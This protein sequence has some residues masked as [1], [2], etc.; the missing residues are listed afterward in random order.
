MA[1]SDT[2]NTQ[3]RRRS[4]YRF[5]VLVAVA[6]VVLLI[7]GFSIPGVGWLAWIGVGL[8]IAAAFTLRLSLM[9]DPANWTPTMFTPDKKDRRPPPP[10]S[11]S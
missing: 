6:A 4:P 8:L 1:T 11:Q 10:S 9:S 3:K 2:E 5:P 7:L